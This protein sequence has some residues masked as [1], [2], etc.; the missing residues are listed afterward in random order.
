MPK[1]QVVKSESYLG[2]IEWRLL[3]GRIQ[4][5][6]HLLDFTARYVLRKDVAAALMDKKQR[7]LLV[8]YRSYDSN[9]GTGGTPPALWPIKR[10]PSG[11]IRIG[12]MLF[13][14]ETVKTI[15]QWAKE[16]A[17]A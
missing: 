10:N 9:W 12:C 6:P 13:S 14:A 11:S 5:Q 8:R 7:A 3:K 16:T 1:F 17:Y 2:P 4:Q 15:R